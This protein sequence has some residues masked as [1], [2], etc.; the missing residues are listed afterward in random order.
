MKTIGFNKSRNSVCQK[1]VEFV[2]QDYVDR[3]TTVL[4][5]LNGLTFFPLNLS[6]P[7]FENLVLGTQIPINVVTSMVELSPESL[8]LTRL[9]DSSNRVF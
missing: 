2:S 4:V 7:V 3:A 8:V 5:D 9:L 1:L 6:L